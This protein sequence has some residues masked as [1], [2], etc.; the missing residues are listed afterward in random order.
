MQRCHFDID[1]FDQA[2]ER[3]NKIKATNS[4]IAEWPVP[5]NQS[6]SGMT[7]LP[8]SKMASNVEALMERPRTFGTP[9]SG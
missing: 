8:A 9:C 2:K 6:V 4:G 5:A 7:K 1:K 3:Q